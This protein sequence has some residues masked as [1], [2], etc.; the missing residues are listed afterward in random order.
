[1]E[2]CGFCQ[3]ECETIEHLLYSCLVVSKFWQPLFDWLKSKIDNITPLDKDKVLF[4]YENVPTK[5]SDLI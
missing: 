4:L 3:E 1:M 5:E 2:P